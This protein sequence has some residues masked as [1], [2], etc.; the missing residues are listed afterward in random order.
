MSAG[1]ARRGDKIV[2]SR[3]VYLKKG[4]DS[5]DH[6]IILGREGVVH[7]ETRVGLGWDLGE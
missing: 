3:A 7:F 1:L 4:L 5:V 2:V 6:R